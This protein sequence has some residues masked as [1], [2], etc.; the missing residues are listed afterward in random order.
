MFEKDFVWGVAAAAYQTEGAVKEDGRTSC[1]WDMYC[2]KGGAIYNGENADIACDFYHRYKEDIKLMKEMG[3]KAFRMSL[4]PVR[5]LPKED[6][7]VNRK[8]ID[9]YNS[10]IDE[11]LK[12][13]ITPFVTLFHWDLPLYVYRKGGFQSRYFAEWFEGYAKVV[14]REFSDRVKYFM[15]FNE[16]QCILGCYKGSGQAPGLDMSDEETVPMVH[17][18]SLAHGKAVRAMRKYGCKD[19]KI[20]YAMQGLYYHPQADTPEN[21]QTA[22]KMCFETDR[23][24]WWTS[25]SVFGDPIVLGK[26]PQ[27]FVKKYGKYLPEKWQKDMS[28]ICPPLDFFGQ[29]YY[30]GQMVDVK[31][32]ICK[33]KPGAWVNAEHWNISPE[34]IRYT[35]QFVQERYKLPIYVTENGM[36]CHDWVSLDGKVHDPQ[37]IDYIERHLIEIYKAKK[38]GADVRGYFCWSVMDNFEWTIGYRPRFGLIYVDFETQERIYKDSALWYKKV[39]ETG[40]KNIHFCDDQV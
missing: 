36:C 30:N 29:N 23:E 19:I 10:V 17:Y 7:K 13:G 40:G 34:G 37:R 22:R 3:V 28:E 38:S 31:G 18:L 11:L 26:Y 15:T 35:L 1:I 8:G 2:R 16:P 27:F 6:G 24:K 9:F 12:S 21:T 14:A 32:N 20:G 39:I 33:D 4:S 5:I 25:P